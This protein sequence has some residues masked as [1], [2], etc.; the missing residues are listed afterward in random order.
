MT[1]IAAITKALGLTP[2]PSEH[3]Y[4]ACFNDTN[5]P[6]ASGLDAVVTAIT[7]APTVTDAFTHFDAE[8]QDDDVAWTV[9]EI[10]QITPHPT[11]P[12]RCD[13]TLA[14]TVHR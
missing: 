3:V 14:L 11:H 5:D 6:N 7:V 2:S 13:W 1:L 8:C 10:W 4:V 9:M 12:R